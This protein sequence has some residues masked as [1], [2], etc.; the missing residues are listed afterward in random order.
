MKAAIKKY[1]TDCRN[2][3]IITPHDKIEKKRYNRGKTQNPS[4]YELCDCCENCGQPI[5]V[6]I[7]ASLVRHPCGVVV[8]IIK[9]PDWIR[10]IQNS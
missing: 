6:P 1:P 3:K 2:C 7:G 8:R 10:E 5:I 4:N 9:P